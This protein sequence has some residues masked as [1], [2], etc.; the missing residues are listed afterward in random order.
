MYRLLSGHVLALID[1]LV[2][3]IERRITVQRGCSPSCLHSSKPVCQCTDLCSRQIGQLCM[4]QMFTMG[5]QTGH[6]GQGHLLRVA[7]T[8]K[9]SDGQNIFPYVWQGL[10]V[11]KEWMVHVIITHAHHWFRRNGLEVHVPVESVPWTTHTQTT[12]AASHR[13]IQSIQLVSNKKYNYCTT[14]QKCFIKRIM[15]EEGK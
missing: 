14:I 5:N 12:V 8:I 3:S 7:V 9:V 6:L 11:V 13:A 10:S 1:D 2:I 15:C 4:I